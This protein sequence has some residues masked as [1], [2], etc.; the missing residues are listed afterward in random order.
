[1]AEK[2]GTKKKLI[3][4]III[5][6]SILI[7]SSFFLAPLFDDR[8]SND[9]HTYAQIYYRL[10]INESQYHN[11]CDILQNISDG[12]DFDRRKIDHG[13]FYYFVTDKNGQLDTNLRFRGSLS[14]RDDYFVISFNMVAHENKE[15]DKELMES[16]LDY[17]KNSLYP[18]LN[19]PTEIECDTV[20]HCDHRNEILMFRFVL[21]LI[22]VSISFVIFICYKI[23]TN[24][25]FKQ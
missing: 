21:F 9:Y 12:Y 16:N 17:I 25:Y 10:R 5:V 24:K 19:E 18:I 7:I 1:M 15:K 13:S 23:I 6:I 20:E 8:E 14:F 2:G 4:E 3:V 22:I 11:V